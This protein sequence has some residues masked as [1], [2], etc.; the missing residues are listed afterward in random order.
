MD[1]WVTK[2]DNIQAGIFG[3]IKQVVTSVIGGDGGV[4]NLC[5]FVDQFLLFNSFKI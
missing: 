4:A 1:S 5:W 2:W 3:L